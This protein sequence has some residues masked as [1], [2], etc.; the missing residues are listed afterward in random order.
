MQLKLQAVLSRAHFSLDHA[1]AQL[2]L[3]WVALFECT[4]YMQH[5]KYRRNS[6]L[7]LSKRFKLTAL[8]VNSADR[9][10]TMTEHCA[11]G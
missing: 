4:M 1:L 3:A 5:D 9:A 8:L 7:I 6:F 11:L 10:S 2:D